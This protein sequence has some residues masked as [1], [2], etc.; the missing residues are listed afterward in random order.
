MLKN[1]NM[2]YDLDLSA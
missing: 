2:Q 1:I